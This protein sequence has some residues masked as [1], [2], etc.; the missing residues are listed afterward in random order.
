MRA[1]GGPPVRPLCRPGRAFDV[2]RVVLDISRAREAFGWAP[3]IGLD[4]G[5]AESWRWVRTT[6]ALQAGNEERPT[7]GPAAPARAGA[8]A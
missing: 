7:T 5:L 8:M 4:E 6:E 1:S 2:P 3:R